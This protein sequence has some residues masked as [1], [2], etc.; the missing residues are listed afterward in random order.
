MGATNTVSQIDSHRWDGI[1]T[2]N[3]CAPEL[4][5]TFCSRAYDVEKKTPYSNPG[6]TTP[7]RSIYVAHA[8]PGKHSPH[9]PC[10]QA[11]SNGNFYHSWWNSAEVSHSSW[12]AINSFNEWH[13]GTQIEPAKAKTLSNDPYDL[14][15]Y[16][17]YGN[18]TKYLTITDDRSDDFM[19]TRVE[20]N[21]PPRCIQSSCCN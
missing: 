5:K 20:A 14:G 6:A 16:L 8:S 2:F 4:R 17:N 15:R 21:N 13:E 10:V 19:N 12:I 1:Y 11:R 3:A 9:K 7:F 18:K